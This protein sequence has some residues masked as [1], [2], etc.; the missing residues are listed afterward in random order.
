MGVV[1]FALRALLLAL[2]L[3][4]WGWAIAS[5]VARTKGDAKRAKAL[6]GRS[7]AAGGALVFV[8]LLATI[9]GVAAAFDAVSSGAVDPS[10]KARIL[11]R[12]SRRR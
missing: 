9:A 7:L 12:G 1:F 6:A 11:G 10:Q 5:L 2:I 4:V 3:G 8:S